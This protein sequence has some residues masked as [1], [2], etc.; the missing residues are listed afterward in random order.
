[1]TVDYPYDVVMS[2]VDVEAQ[3]EHFS[4]Y[5]DDQFYGE[6]GGENGY[7]NKYVGNW[8]NPEWCLLNGYTRGYFRIPAGKFSYVERP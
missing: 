3:S 5:L 7:V 1:M 6:T 2:I 8:G 4:I